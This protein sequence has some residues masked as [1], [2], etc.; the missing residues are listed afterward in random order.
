[1]FPMRNL[2]LPTSKTSKP[3]IRVPTPL[4]PRDEILQ[5]GILVEPPADTP[6]TP[7]ASRPPPRPVPLLVFPEARVLCASLHTRSP[8][9]GTC[10]PRSG[11]LTVYRELVNPVTVQCRGS[12]PTALPS[13]ALPTLPDDV[14]EFA[15]H[16]IDLISRDYMR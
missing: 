2:P 12:P 6:R 5:R 13:C 10:L 11:T 4:T 1:M 16:F 3:R 14:P 15:R 9:P 8:G 7:P